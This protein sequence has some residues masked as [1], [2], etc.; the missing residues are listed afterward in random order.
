MPTEITNP[1][2]RRKNTKGFSAP[3]NTA[4]PNSNV[5]AKARGKHNRASL[6]RD[7]YARIG[8][9]GMRAYYDPNCPRRPTFERVKSRGAQTLESI[10]S[11][12]KETDY[13]TYASKIAQAKRENKEDAKKAAQDELLKYCTDQHIDPSQDQQVQALLAL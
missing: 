7:M 9:L 8:G 6:P 5:R 12:L 11:L 1:L 13:S 10:N 4:S 3:G 2:V